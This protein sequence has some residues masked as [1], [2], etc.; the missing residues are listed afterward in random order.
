MHKLLM[1]AGGAALLIFANSALAEDTP[2]PG[3]QKPAEGMPRATFEQ[4][5][6]NADGKLV[7]DEI[8]AK[9]PNFSEAR[10]KARDMDGDGSISPQE[11]KNKPAV[12]KQEANA[13]APGDLFKRADKDTSGTLTPEEALAIAPGFTEARF[14]KFDKNA[15]GLLTLDEVP[16][17]RANQDQKKQP[18]G[19]DALF[20]RVDENKDG[21]VEFE[22]LAKVTPKSTR[23]SFDQMDAN[24]D[25]ALSREEMLAGRAAAKQEEAAMP[26]VAI[27]QDEAAPAMQDKKAAAIPNPIQLM[28]KADTD[29]NGSITFEELAA[30]TPDLARERFDKMDVNKDGVLSAAD[31]AQGTKDKKQETEVHLLKLLM[32]DGDKDG[33]VTFEEM[34]AA[35]PGF[36]R[37]AFDKADR[38]KDGVLSITDK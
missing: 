11:M 8:K 1:A 10:F 6:A 26:K 23:E 35:K 20:T 28:R 2:K 36:P 4:L 7:L 25:G 19:A 12:A 13:L 17:P 32:S 31:R 27:K 30:V 37:E 15:D 9:I 34:E 5:D 18:R 16:Q 33:N 3:K 22:E 38:N 21:K 24:K 14:K 29:R